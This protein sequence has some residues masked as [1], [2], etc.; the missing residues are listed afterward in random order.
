ME[1]EIRPHV[2][3]IRVIQKRAPTRCRIRFDGISESA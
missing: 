3:M 2:I 1:A